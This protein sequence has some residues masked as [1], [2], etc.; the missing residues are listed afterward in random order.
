MKRMKASKAAMDTMTPIFREATPPTPAILVPA[1]VAAFF[2]AALVILVPTW[3]A[4]FL[5]ASFHA[6]AVA[7]L[8]M[9]NGLPEPD[10]PTVLRFLVF[11]TF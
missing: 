11:L 5:V 7:F 4:A 3:F 8:A 6:V 9:F 2:P 1:A 10:M